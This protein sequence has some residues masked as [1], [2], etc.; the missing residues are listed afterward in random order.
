MSDSPRDD[1]SGES[2][3]PDPDPNRAGEAND[4][5]REGEVSR[6][7]TERHPDARPA[8]DTDRRPGGPDRG[9]DPGQSTR[10]DTATT[11]VLKWLSGVVALVGIW[12]A[13]SPFLYAATEVATWNN[14]VVGVVIFLLAGYNFY[15][16][17]NDQRASIGGSS[18]VVLLGLW[19]IIAPLLLAF[20]SEA[21]AWSTLASGIAV[22]ILSGYN[23]YE[24][25]RA[26]TAPQA[27]TRA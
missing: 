26:A 20:G 4:P 19:S 11:G 5:D 7:D 2:S 15:R 8:G 18:L 14:V 25:R 17:M 16:M 13:V 6:S 10:A 1:R 22:V 12:I 23:A 21:L 3:D 24:S 9:G 27:E